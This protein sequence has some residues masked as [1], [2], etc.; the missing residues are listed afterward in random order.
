MSK[1]WAELVK[2]GVKTQ[3]YK[4]EIFVTKV[5]MAL[6]GSE[7]EYGWQEKLQQITEALKELDS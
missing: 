2:P 5:R 1:P 6:S 3:F 7:A 4:M